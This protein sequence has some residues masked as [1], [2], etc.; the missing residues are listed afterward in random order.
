MSAQYIC[1]RCGF[2]CSIET[3]EVHRTCHRLEDD[4]LLQRHDYDSWSI[5]P[6][7]CLRYLQRPLEQQEPRMR[8]Q[9]QQWV[10]EQLKQLGAS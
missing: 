2:I 7:G 6:T 4:G 1:Q 10:D 5:D 3:A 9:V 8:A